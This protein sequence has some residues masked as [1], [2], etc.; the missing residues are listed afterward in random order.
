MAR[1]Q[2]IVHARGYHVDQHEEKVELIAGEMQ[3][4]T[5]FLTCPSEH[6]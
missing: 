5:R 2:W 4:H 1:E 3:H 6:A